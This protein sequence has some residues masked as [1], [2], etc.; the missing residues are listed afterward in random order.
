MAAEWASRFWLWATLL[1]PAAAVYEDQVGK[2]DCVAP[3]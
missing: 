1:I 2:F 3:C